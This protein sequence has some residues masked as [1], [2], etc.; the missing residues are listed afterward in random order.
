MDDVNRF[1]IFGAELPC[2]IETPGCAES[3]FNISVD[4]PEQIKLNTTYIEV[5]YTDTDSNGSSEIMRYGRTDID[6]CMDLTQPGYYTLSNNVDFATDAIEYNESDYYICFE[7]MSD[8]VTL[9][10]D[11]HSLRGPGAGPSQT[12]SGA[13][14]SSNSQNV[15]VVNCNITGTYYPLKYINVTDGSIENYTLYTSDFTGSGVRST[16]EIINSTRISLNNATCPLSWFGAQVTNTD[17]SNFT[18]F[19]FV[20]SLGVTFTFENSSYNIVRDGYVGP[21]TVGGLGF[22]D[23]SDYNLI[24][25]I[26]SDDVGDITGANA[27]AMGAQDCTGNWFI[28][29]TAYDWDIDMGFDSCTNTNISHNEIYNSSYGI[30]LNNSQT[31]NVFNNTAE[32]FPPNIANIRLDFADNNHV[33]NNSFTDG[34]YGVY[35]NN[36]DDNQIDDMYCNSVGFCLNLVDSDD[37]DVDSPVV[38]NQTGGSA[39]IF[40]NADNNNL[41]NANITDMSY[42]IRLAF[43][44]EGNTLYNPI[45]I[46]NTQALED[47]NASTT[48]TLM[49]DNG[50][51]TIRWGLT[52][53]TINGTFTF[54]GT[55]EISHNLAHLDTPAFTSNIEDTATITLLNLTEIEFPSILRDT[56]LCLDCIINNW[57]NTTKNIIFTVTGWTNYSVMDTNQTTLLYFCPPFVQINE[58]FVIW[59]DYELVNGSDVLL[60]NVTVSNATVSYNLTYNLSN[61]RYDEIFNSAT[62][63]TWSVTISASKFGY[64]TQTATCD[65][66]ITDFF[67]LTVLI[68]QEKELEKYEVEDGVWI[69]QRN[70]D[71]ELDTPYLND[72]SVI[73]AVN[74]DLNASGAYDY[75]NVPV[76]GAQSLFGA[77]NAY[78]WLGDEM[79]SII[80]HYTGD[81]IGCNKYWFYTPYRSGQA[82]LP[83]PIDGNYSLYLLEGV[84]EWP[85]PYSPPRIVKS[86]LFLPLGNL[87]IPDMNPYTIDY[88]VSHDELDWWSFMDSYYV[89]LVIFIPFLIGAVLIYAGIPPKWV[90]IF[91]LG[92]IIVWTFVRVL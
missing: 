91:V 56:D 74:H 85:E 32:G 51:G 29:N 15:R 12:E 25:N 83:L 68:W 77:F 82:K 67:N 16:F 69:T 17:N 26:T 81:H 2:D 48:N 6:Y 42:G 90:A 24:A 60:A 8:N 19:N 52:N 20:S 89:L 49:Y 50:N 33:Y 57:D 40:F 70:Y 80:T 1:N 31:M 7:I 53:L 36:S 28:N 5:N 84:I 92:W 46:N 59:A 47:L 21:S 41:S 23:G 34:V 71:K 9:D 79:T 43:S 30:Y 62:A 39:V 14:E 18:N 87:E 27:F 4:D 35:L 78:N 88:W 37:N 44:S 45:L 61:S 73:L 86:N 3:I 76:G 75:C 54:P 22:I 66:I 10:C 11:G 38:T 64:Q 63:F 55:I 13:I 58:D 65:I 72:F